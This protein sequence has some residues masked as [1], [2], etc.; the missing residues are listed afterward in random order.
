MVIGNPIDPN[1]VPLLEEGFFIP[2]DHT[3][4]FEGRSYTYA[5]KLHDLIGYGKLHVML[6]DEEA[7]LMWRKYEQEMKRE[8]VKLEETDLRRGYLQRQAEKA[9]KRAMLYEISWCFNN[10]GT[11]TPHKYTDMNGEEKTECII[12]IR[13]ER[14]EMAIANQRKYYE[15]WLKMLDQRSQAPVESEA[16]SDAAEMQQFEEVCQALTRK[17]NDGLFS[18]PLL[19]SRMKKLVNNKT[20]TGLIATYIESRKLQAFYGDG[21]RAIC[22][23]H[24]NAKDSNWFD[25]QKISPSFKNPPHFYKYFE[26]GGA[27]ES[28]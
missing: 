2:S 8:A 28:C 25:E 5:K 16:H 6:S 27:P 1:N 21:S 9:L 24:K 7:D 19:I 17:F 15:Y 26:K 12:P 20:L 18:R 22:N 3:A 14:M 23:P 13:K 11:I 4:D 10:I